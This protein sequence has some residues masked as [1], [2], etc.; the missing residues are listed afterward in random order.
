[1]TPQTPI[2]PVSLPKATAMTPSAKAMFD[3]ETSSQSTAYEVDV[4]PLLPHSLDISLELSKAYNDRYDPKA[5][6]FTADAKRR[7]IRADEAFFNKTGNN[8]VIH[9]ATRTVRRQA[10]LYIDYTWHNRG[11]SASW[12]GCSYHNWGLAADMVETDRENIVEAMNKAGWA[13]TYEAGSWHFE[14]TSSPDHAQATTKISKFRTQGSG[15]A[16]RWSEQVA[17]YYTK[18]RDYNERKPIYDKRLEA[19]QSV[20]QALNADKEKFSQ[21]LDDFRKR[22]DQYNDGVNFHNSERD[23]A[24]RMAD[25]RYAMPPGPERD[26]KAAVFHQLND[27]LK[28]DFVRLDNWYDE[29]EKEDNLLVER[30]NDLVQ[31]MED[32]QK[33]FDWLANENEALTKLDTEKTEHNDRAN[34]LLDEIDMAVLHDFGYSERHVL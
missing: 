13:N 29:L 3:I 31:R 30:E 34:T 25:E 5:N 33:E 9:S 11:N 7:Y 22:V 21:D 4:L 27:W 26:R 12:P 17:H 23:R 15:L 6:D 24:Q 28:A 19:H 8:M 1:M 32:F 10:Q 18:I 2:A 20:E 14:C 16:Y